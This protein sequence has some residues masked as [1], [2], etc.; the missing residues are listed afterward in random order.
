MRVGKK[1]PQGDIQLDGFIKE[2]ENTLAASATSL[3]ISNLDGNVDIEYIIEVRIVNDYNGSVTYYLQP[4]NDSTPG[5]YGYAFVYGWGA[6]AAAAVSTA[7]GLV[8]GNCGALNHISWSRTRLR[9]KSG[10]NRVAVTEKVKQVTGTTPTFAEFWGQVWNNSADNIT[11][12]VLSASAANG[13][14]VGTYICLWKRVGR[15]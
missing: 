9:A 14:G 7:P 6:T 13:L 8:C 10:F 4:N 1:R 5:G 3:T 15:A 2:Y 12:I 11:S